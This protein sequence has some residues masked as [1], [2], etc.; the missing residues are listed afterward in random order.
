MS[1]VGLV[2]SIDASSCEKT[3]DPPLMHHL[4][5]STDTSDDTNVAPRL[6]QCYCGPG[7]HPLAW[8]GGQLMRFDLPTLR[9]GVVNFIRVPTSPSCWGT[10]RITRLRYAR[11]LRIV[12]EN[13]GDV[14]MRR[15][16][17]VEIYRMIFRHAHPREN[18]TVRFFIDTT[19][20]HAMRWNDDRVVV[21][22]WW[23]SFT[24]CTG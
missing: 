12:G 14:A 4:V 11:V 19:S 13:D 23:V 15:D 16:A 24:G 10:R 2:S 20:S 17:H 6:A 3:T 18:I 22:H 7:T 9:L 8:S 21:A 5:N 1:H